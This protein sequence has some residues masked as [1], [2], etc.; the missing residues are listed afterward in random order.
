MALTTRQVRRLVRRLEEAGDQ[1][2]IHALRGVPSNRRL[3]AE[4][5]QQVLAQ[6]QR[7]Y[8]GFGPTLASDKLAEQGL[9]VSHD[10]LRRWLM[11]AGWWQGERKRDK[12]RQGRT[13]CECF[14]ELAQM[15]TSIH[16]WLEGRGE[17]MVLV[18]MIDD[19]TGQVE[20]GF[21][22]GE[23][24]EAH[25]DLLGRWLRKHGR[26][27]ALY[28]DRD[29]IFEPSGKG[30]PDPAGETRFGR[31][32]DDLA[33]DRITAYS[34][35]AKGRVERFFGTAQDRWVK[36][37]RLAA[38]TTMAQ[39][40]ALLRQKLLPEFNRRFTVT[41]ARRR[42]E[43]YTTGPAPGDAEATAATAGVSERGGCNETKRIGVGLVSH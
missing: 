40:N 23:T 33:I 4:L 21:Y 17:R 20:A 19:V 14:G 41:A 3:S 28:I 39:A 26:P 27:V 11:A 24:V 6:Y 30:H 25:F 9:R 31:A 34:P 1:G 7:F 42:L 18:A 38:V 35:Q 16:D 12:H 13:R 22:S 8:V 36:E 10:T 32:L 29:S 15:D 43:L 2:L 37:L 5:R